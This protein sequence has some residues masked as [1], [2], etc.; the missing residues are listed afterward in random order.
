MV[1]KKNILKILSIE[2]VRLFCLNKAEGLERKKIKG[3]ED[4][5]E[6]ECTWKRG[7][8]KGVDSLQGTKIIL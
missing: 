7:T 2:I 6:L 1:F 4:I 5:L 3:L 8:E